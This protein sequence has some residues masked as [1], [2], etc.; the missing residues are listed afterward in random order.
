MIGNTLQIPLFED[1]LRDKNLSETTI[2]VYTSTV[3]QFL[4]NNPNVENVE[5]YNK[6]LIKHSIEKR[7][8][9]HYYALKAYIKWTFDDVKS[10]NE[11]IRNLIKIKPREDIKR[12]RKHLPD[13]KLMTLINGMEH[14]K[15]RVIAII[16]MFTGIRAGDILRLKKGGIVIEEYEDRK[17]MKLNVVGK[18]KKQRPV[19]IHNS[20][21]IDFILHFIT[22]NINTYKDYYFVQLQQRK[23]WRFKIKSNEQLIA[24]NYQWLWKDLRESLIKLGYSPKDFSTHDFRRCFARKVWEKWKDVFVLQNM[25]GH[26]DPKVTFRYLRQSGLQNIDYFKELQK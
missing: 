2:F 17:V 26:R 4:E 8:Y 5:D 13:E 11:I 22:T 6:F 24:T 21:V 3:K 23:R 9:N 15:H 19:H 20:D 16:M 1:H 12:E 14:L 7:T 25:L 10:R 18:G